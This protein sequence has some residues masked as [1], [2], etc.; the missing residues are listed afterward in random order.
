MTVMERNMMRFVAAG[1]FA[2]GLA[3][4]GG[5]T[6]ALSQSPA[7]NVEESKIVC[8]YVV[9]ATPGS[10]PYRM[11]LSKADWALKE[12]QDAKDPNRIVCHYEQ[13]PGS[14]LKG[15]K[16][17]QPASQWAQDKQDYRD[18]TE[19]IQMLTPPPH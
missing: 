19:R 2:F 6:A 4:V 1:A 17:C 12:Q 15:R 8:K 7:P 13:E 9:A 10:K 5:G 16:V 14:R 18:S 3:A 11:C